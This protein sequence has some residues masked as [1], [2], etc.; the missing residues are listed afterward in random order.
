MKDHERIHPDTRA[1]IQ[2]TSANGANVM[3]IV[4]W[5][6]LA[7][8]ELVALLAEEVWRRPL[9][10]DYS[11]SF[12]D[13]GYG[14]VGI[15]KSKIKCFVDHFGRGRPLKERRVIE[16]RVRA[17][18]EEIF[19]KRIAEWG[20]L[21]LKSG[22]SKKVDVTREVSRCSPRGA[23]KQVKAYVIAALNL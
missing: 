17:R 12:E 19:K 2:I 8:D 4:A 14:R 13:R 21:V 22:S 18:A 23:R 10:Q 5:A 1:S 11:G 3:V 6:T 7:D 16:S 15:T 20:K 9:L